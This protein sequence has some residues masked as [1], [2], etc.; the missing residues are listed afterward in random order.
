MAHPPTELHTYIQPYCRILALKTGYTFEDLKLDLQ[1]DQNT[2][3]IEN[4]KFEIHY[5]VLN[6]NKYLKQINFTKTA[7]NIKVIHLIEFMNDFKIPLLEYLNHVRY[8]STNPNVEIHKNISAV[9]EH[10]IFYTSIWKI[11]ETIINI[12]LD[13]IAADLH[14]GVNFTY[15]I[16]YEEI[17]EYGADL[18]VCLE[19][20]N[21]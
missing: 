6:P 4:T 18:Y 15:G 16:T 10:K 13:R 8:V 17:N 12:I 9:L 14:V 2:S 7:D 3:Y 20:F 11:Y 1:T 21:N 19:N 5:D